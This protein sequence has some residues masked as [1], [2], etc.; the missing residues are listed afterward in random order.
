VVEQVLGS[1]IPVARPLSDA[2][3]EER[4]LGSDRP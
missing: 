2:V 4:S 1:K 3:H